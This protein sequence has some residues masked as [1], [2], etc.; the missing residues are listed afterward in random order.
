MTMADKSKTVIDLD[1]KPRTAF[2]SAWREFRKNRLALIGG[3]FVVMVILS[4]IF[5][6]LIT[7]YDLDYQN[8]KENREKPLTGYTISQ[9]QAD[10]C[11]WY[12]TPLEWG[13][14]VFMTGSDALGRDLYSRVI[15][16]TRV[17][18]AVALVGSTVALVFGI[19]F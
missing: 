10:R 18:L 6:P 9:T 5:A 19:I 4:A 7:P 16:G 14:T 8:I 15:Y 12:K 13:C 3:I 2:S 17:S 11:H 1:S